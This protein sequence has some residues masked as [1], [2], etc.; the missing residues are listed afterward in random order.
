MAIRA[1]AFPAVPAV[2]QEGIS[3]WEFQTLNAMK[4][5]IDLLTGVRGVSSKTAIT[6]GTVTVI[7]LQAG[8]QQLTARGAGYTVSN[9]TVPSL[10]DYVRLVGNVQQLTNDVATLRNTLNTLIT[11]L[12]G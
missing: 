10:D 2:P 9:V 5:N 11:Q 6:R 8:L 3:N 7:P 1:P 12:K 4:E